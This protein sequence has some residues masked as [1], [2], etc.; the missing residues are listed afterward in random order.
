[1]SSPLVSHLSPGSLTFFTG[2]MFSG[3]TL[4]LVRHLQIFQEQ[5]IPQICLQPSFDTRTPT[6]QSKS[7]LL[8]PSTLVDANDNA[9]IRELVRD[10]FVIGI[11]EVQ[12]FTLELIPILEG[13]LRKGKTILVAGLDTDFRAVM[14]PVSQ[15]LMALP[16]TIVERSRS[17]CSVCRQYNATRTQRLRNGQPVP[18]NES[19]TVIE[20]SESAM[21]YEARCLEHHVI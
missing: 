11:D 19:S 3:K 7:G 2:P 12:F 13:E 1:M 5:K 18:P 16:E 17:V 9:R 10:K 15:A 21:T 6:V 20:N 8:I 4:E 14:F